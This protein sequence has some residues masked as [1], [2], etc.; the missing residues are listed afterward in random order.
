MI[1]VDPC[2]FR[3]TVGIISGRIS[4]ELCNVL[5][6]AVFESNFQVASSLRLRRR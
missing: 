2:C 4:S 1:L 6:K 5:Y 3:I